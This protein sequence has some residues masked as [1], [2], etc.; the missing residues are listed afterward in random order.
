MA[1]TLWTDDAGLPVT[2]DQTRLPFEQ[3][4]IALH[5]AEACAR[6]IATTWVRGAPLIRPVGPWG[7]ALACL[8]YTSD[9]CAE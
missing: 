1:R 9:P 8:F 3:V 4:A 7:L 2:W 5:D 6:A